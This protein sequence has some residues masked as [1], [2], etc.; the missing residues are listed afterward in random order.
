MS[1]ILV[2]ADSSESDTA[3]LAI[4]GASADKK[5]RKTLIKAASDRRCVTNLLLIFSSSLPVH[6]S[7]VVSL[8]NARRCS[9]AGNLAFGLGPV[10]DGICQPT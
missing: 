7:L 10:N 4:R 3:E 9:L 5:N 6:L 8:V 2:A 1:D